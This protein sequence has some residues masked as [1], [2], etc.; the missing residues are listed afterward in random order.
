[1]SHIKYGTTIPEFVVRYRRHKGWSQSDMG[2][3]MGIC[4]Q[5]VSN[6]ERGVYSCPMR[7]CHR[8]MDILDDRRR[9]YLI[10]LLTEVSQGG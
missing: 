3:A 2:K 5:Y 7:F 1:M 10:D 4:A 6:I 8:L 9:S